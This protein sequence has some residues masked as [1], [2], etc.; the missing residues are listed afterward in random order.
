MVICAIDDEE[1]HIGGG[2]EIYSQALPYTDRLYLTLIQ[3]KKDA[4]TF[5]PDYTEFTKVISE[6]KREHNGLHYTWLTLER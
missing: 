2:S 5:F 6:E 1:I 3:D 4:D